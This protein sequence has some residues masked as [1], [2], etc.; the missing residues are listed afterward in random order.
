MLL[1]VVLL[2]VVVASHIVYVRGLFMLRGLMHALWL[3]QVEPYL[4]DISMVSLVPPGQWPHRDQRST[5]QCGSR[6]ELLLTDA[7]IPEIT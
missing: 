2:V 7:P 1:A 6:D 3:H 5:S 4:K